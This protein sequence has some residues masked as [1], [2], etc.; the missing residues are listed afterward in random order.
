MIDPQFKL[1]PFINTLCSLCSIIIIN[2]STMQQEKQK[3]EIAARVKV[4]C[5]SAG[6]RMVG[7]K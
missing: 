3:E 7:G 6:G 1:T 4:Q 2:C 5:K